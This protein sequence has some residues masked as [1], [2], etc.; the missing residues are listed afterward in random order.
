MLE[1]TF[2]TPTSTGAARAPA[3]VA[4]NGTAHDA[5]LPTLSPSVEHAVCAACIAFGAALEF[6]TSV[7]ASRIC[8]ATETPL[9]AHSIKRLSWLCHDS[10]MAP[11]FTDVHVNFT[12]N[13]LDNQKS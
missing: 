9:E 13:V 2:A 8:A 12:T 7:F 1:A 3:L 11:L 5:H 10:Y 4:A 6:A